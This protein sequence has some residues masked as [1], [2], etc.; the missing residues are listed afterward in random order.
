MQTISNSEKNN[1]VYDKIIDNPDHFYDLHDNN[2]ERNNNNND[3]GENIDNSN[4][5]NI[6]S[7]SVDLAVDEIIENDEEKTTKM[8]RLSGLLIIG[9]A[10][11]IAFIITIINYILPNKYQIVFNNEQMIVDMMQKREVYFEAIVESCPGLVNFVDDQVQNP[12]KK[13]MFMT[14]FDIICNINSIGDKDYSGF[15]ELRQQSTAGAEPFN[16]EEP[17]G[18]EVRGQSPLLNTNNNQSTKFTE[19]DF[20]NIFSQIKQEVDNKK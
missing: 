13:L 16:A 10:E 5:N 19:T 18:Q 17:R 3:N 4:N 14:S 15:R 2:N 11:T 1:D 7:E 9:M 20:K 12:K 8:K 6:Q